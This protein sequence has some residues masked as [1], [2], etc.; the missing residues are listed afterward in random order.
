[1]DI[2]EDNKQLFTLFYPGSKEE[3][4][5]REEWIASVVGCFNAARQ[6]N[7]KRYLDEL[8][9]GRHSDAEIAAAW[10]SASPSYDFSEGG[11][12]IFLTEVRAMIQ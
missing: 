7:I 5:T 12:R 6:Q 9:S 2:P 1:M 3:V 8:L 4:P 11:H 10:R